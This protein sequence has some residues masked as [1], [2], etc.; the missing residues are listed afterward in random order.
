MSDMSP[1]S[2]SDMFAMRAWYDDKWVSEAIS[3]YV[4]FL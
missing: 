1:R 4:L 2:R 3:E